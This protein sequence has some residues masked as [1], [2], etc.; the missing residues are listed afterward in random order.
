[1]TDGKVTSFIIM[2]GP[3]GARD[4]AARENFRQYTKD[5]DIA[6]LFKRDTFVSIDSTSSGVRSIE[7]TKRT[8][9]NSPGGRLSSVQNA[10]GG[11]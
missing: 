11:R 10:E 5:H 4:P 3:V 9:Q 1:M 6:I 7:T 2:D 8:S